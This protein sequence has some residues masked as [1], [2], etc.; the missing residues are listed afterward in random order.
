[1]K[2]EWQLEKQLEVSGCA[3]EVTVGSEKK[4]RQV[5]QLGY[6]GERMIPE[7][8]GGQGSWT[9]VVGVAGRQL[10]EEF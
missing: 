2:R 3:E 5:K 1:M 9:A 4:E 10:S 7:T 8:H 6:F